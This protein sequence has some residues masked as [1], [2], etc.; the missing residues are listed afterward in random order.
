MNHSL[1]RSHAM[2]WQGAKLRFDRQKTGEEVF[3]IRRNITG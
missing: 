1:K 3:D 2:A